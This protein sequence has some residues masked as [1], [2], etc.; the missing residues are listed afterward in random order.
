LP[1]QMKTRQILL[2]LVSIT[3][4]NGTSFRKTVWFREFEVF[5]PNL[6]LRRCPHGIC[7]LSALFTPASPG[8]T[9]EIPSLRF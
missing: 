1:R 6:V 4:K 8:K 2:D 5:E 7:Q 3:I 9:F